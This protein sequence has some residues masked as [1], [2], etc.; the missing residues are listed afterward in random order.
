MGGYRGRSITVHNWAPP[1]PAAEPAAV[2]ALRREA[3]ADAATTLAGYVGRLHEVKGVDLLIAVFRGLPHAGA[4]L[5]I[6]GDGPARPEL[7][8]QAAGD[9][10]IVFLGHRPN[11]AAAYAALDLLVMPSRFDPFPLVALEAMAAGTPMLAAAVG[12]LAE[13]FASAPERL[14]A[15]EDIGALSERLAAALGRPGRAPRVTYDLS[16]FEPAQAAARIEGFYREVMA[17]ARQGRA[18]S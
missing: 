9:P 12:G 16:R 5:A 4:R 17:D 18:A 8:A 14:F 1:L 6:V 15:P 11:P 7:E 13:M 10:R 3:G 2:E